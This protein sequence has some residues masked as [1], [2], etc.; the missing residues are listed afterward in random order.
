M[1][2]APYSKET[3]AEKKAVKPLLRFRVGQLDKH[4]YEKDALVNI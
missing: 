4:S 1:C 2:V 3:R